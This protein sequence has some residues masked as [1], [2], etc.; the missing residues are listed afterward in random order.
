[1][2]DPKS[3][4]YKPNYVVYGYILPNASQK[5]GKKMA[6]KRTVKN[7]K[8]TIKHKRK[9]IKSHKNVK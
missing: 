2:P 9:F 3:R 4:H 1:M 7:N 5:G 8:K 6:C